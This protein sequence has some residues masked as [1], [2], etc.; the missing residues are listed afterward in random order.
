MTLLGDGQTIA[1][2]VARRDLGPARRAPRECQTNRRAPVRNERVQQFGIEPSPFTAS[3]LKER[4]VRLENQT[5]SM[6]RNR[7]GRL[8][9]FVYRPSDKLLVNKE[10][11]R[12]DMDTATS[13]TLLTRPG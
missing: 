3:L 12:Q 11:I 4:P 9:A 5:A 2:R 8:L 6:S 10:I 13:R 1:D 7:F